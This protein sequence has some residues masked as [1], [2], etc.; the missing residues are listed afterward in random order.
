MFTKLYNNNYELGENGKLLKKILLII[1]VYLMVIEPIFVF[2]RI[3]ILLLNTLKNILIKCAKR[4]L[5]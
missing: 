3:N 2:Q 4:A 1:I 5:F